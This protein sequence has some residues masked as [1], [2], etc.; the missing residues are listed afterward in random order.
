MTLCHFK[1]SA[2]MI[3][4][5]IREFLYDMDRSSFLKRELMRFDMDG[6]L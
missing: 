2:D 5:G 3:G 6:Y 1:L 4:D